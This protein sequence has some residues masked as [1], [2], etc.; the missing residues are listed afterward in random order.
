[1]GASSS[2]ETCS[3]FD[4]K[5]LGLLK[6]SY[7]SPC[8]RLPTLHQNLKSKCKTF[9]DWTTL[10]S[11]LL[12][13]PLPREEIDA[14][15]CHL[16]HIAETIVLDNYCDKTNLLILDTIFLNKDPVLPSTLEMFYLSLEIGFFPWKLLYDS[17][18]NGQS[19]LMLYHA[20]QLYESTL[21]IIKDTS[22]HEFGVY[23]PNAISPSHEFQCNDNTLLISMV[24]N[25]K[26]YRN[27]GINKN[28]VYF[29]H[30]QKQVLN[31]FGCGGQIGFFAL[32]LSDEF[33]TGYSMSNTATFQNECLSGSPEFVVEQVRVFGVTEKEI[34]E[35][36]VTEPKASILNDA[37]ASSLLE[38]AG[39]KL[40]SKDLPIEES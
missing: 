12:I 15:I 10:Y 14:G 28:N 21:L 39:K 27:S 32:F 2:T 30:G 36:Y 3:E 13:N 5:T 40:Y 11:H 38:M 19:S 35:R 34:D 18:V 29:N 22:N 4:I 1:M 17:S 33:G 23:I 26:I 16:L 24:P 25:F 37:G 20:L 9:Q 7:N 8:T 31:G 6:H